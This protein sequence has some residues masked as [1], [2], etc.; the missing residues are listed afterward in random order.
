[1]TSEYCQKHDDLIVTSTYGYIAS[2]I[3]SDTPHCA[4]NRHPWVISAQPGQIIN[5]TLYDFAVDWSG[6]G[7]DGSPHGA[8]PAGRSS[9]PR[10]AA[11]A[12]RSGPSTMSLASMQAYHDRAVTKSEPNKRCRKYGTIED[13]G[14]GVDRPV[15]ICG[16]STQ[17][18]SSLY[19][20]TGNVVKL[21]I[22]AGMAPRDLQRF[23]IQYSGE[24]DCFHV[25]S[26]FPR[27]V[28]R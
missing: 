26:K 21:W 13:D 15:T 2:I 18:V 28:G 24:I 27:Y 19:T 11:P 17:R 5:L 10:G 1:M 25:M 4:G 14:A 3:T 20:S 9:G 22:T 7:G 16:S 12:G 8:A 23:I 6:D